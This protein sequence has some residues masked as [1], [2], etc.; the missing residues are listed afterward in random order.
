MQGVELVQD[1]TEPYHI[2]KLDSFPYSRYRFEE[3]GGPK[4]TFVLLSNFTGS[5][6]N[7]LLN[8]YSIMTLCFDISCSGA[9]RGR[10]VDLYAV[11]IRKPIQSLNLKE[12]YEQGGQG[13]IIHMT[14]LEPMANAD[15]SL[16]LS[17]THGR[18]QPSI[19]NTIICGAN[20][21]RVMELYRTSQEYFE[22]LRH[23]SVPKEWVMALGLASFDFKLGTE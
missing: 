14:S 17:F 12:S 22:V 2:K 1:N 23:R 16:S 13:D 5:Q 6:Y 3:I 21:E 9:N 4:R 11:P 18:I 15:G 8:G 10:R 19:E 7:L 20:G